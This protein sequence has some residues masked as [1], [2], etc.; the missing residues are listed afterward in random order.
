[1]EL[2]CAVDRHGVATPA[3]PPQLQAKSQL[4]FALLKKSSNGA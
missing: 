4:A 1:V 3:R 2:W